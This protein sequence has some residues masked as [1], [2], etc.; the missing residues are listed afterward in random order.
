MYKGKEENKKCIK[1]K[2]NIGKLIREK[3]MLKREKNMLMKC[4]ECGYVWKY[5][6]VGKIYCICPFCRYKVNI[7]T[8][9]I[10]KKDLWEYSDYL[11]KGDL[12]VKQKK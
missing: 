8:N 7:K 4:R 11:L 3:N 9:R 5:K 12:E 10:L 6:G 1:E 2:E